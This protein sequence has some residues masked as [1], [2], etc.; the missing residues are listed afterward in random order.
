MEP[1]VPFA[2]GVGGGQIGQERD[3]N[4]LEGVAGAHAGTYTLARVEGGSLSDGGKQ[5][6][7]DGGSSR[8]GPGV[9]TASRIR[10]ARVQPVGDTGLGKCKDSPFKEC[11]GQLSL[12]G[13]GQEAAE[14]AGCRRGD[15]WPRGG[16]PPSRAVGAHDVKGGLEHFRM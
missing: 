10:E 8:C 15:A 14:L 4:S 1:G 16:M 2:G 7:G 12:D 13:S 3:A 6:V 5:G 11:R 9:G